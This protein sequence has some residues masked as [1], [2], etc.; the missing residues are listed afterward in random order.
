MI[1]ANEISTSCTFYNLNKINIHTQQKTTCDDTVDRFKFYKSYCCKSCRR[2]CPRAVVR[3]QLKTRQ[4]HEWRQRNDNFVLISATYITKLYRWMNKY[5]F[6]DD[7]LKSIVTSVILFAI[8][9]EL[10]RKLNV[11]NFI[12]NCH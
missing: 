7:F 6:V 12:Q 2:I 10:T 4:R 5:L 9:V 1:F 11:R 3:S 8:G